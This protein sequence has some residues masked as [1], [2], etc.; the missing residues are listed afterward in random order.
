VILRGSH[1]RRDAGFS[2]AELLVFMALLGVVLTLAYS[3]SQ[4]ISAGQR[5]A[6]MQTGLARS[7]TYPMTRMS[8]IL[9]QNARIESVPA[10]SAQTL[11]V[12]TDQDLNDLQ[13]QHNFSI[14][15]ADGDTFIEHS[16]FRLTAAGARVLPARFVNRYG[17]GIT[18]VSGG[19]PLFRYFNAAG[20]EITDMTKVIA[21][22]RSV[23]ITIRAQV[24]GRP[25]QDSVRVTFRNR[26]I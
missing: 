16:S 5:N 13:E 22:A 6:D 25:I 9:V 8:E 4:A 20:V 12:R 19:V 7:I 10:A 17:P 11:S 14:V 2:L 18:N 26:D 15:T 24:N 23:Q 1:T 21:E 3:I